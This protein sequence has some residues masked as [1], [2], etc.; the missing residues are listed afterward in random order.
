MIALPALLAVALLGR[1][2]TTAARQ[3]PS[4]ATAL[5][6]AAGKGLGVGAYREY[7]HRR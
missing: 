7:R 2:T 4:E 3:L 6:K 5:A 1:C